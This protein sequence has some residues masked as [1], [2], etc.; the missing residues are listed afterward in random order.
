MK[1]VCCIFS[2][3]DLFLPKVACHDMAT[4]PLDLTLAAVL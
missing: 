4:F 3:N 2:W 1:F